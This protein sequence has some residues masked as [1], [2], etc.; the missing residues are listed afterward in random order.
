MFF[1][2]ILRG[3]RATPTI[4][5]MDLAFTKMHK[6]PKKIPSNRYAFGLCIL[7]SYAFGE[8]NLAYMSKESG[9][10]N[11]DYGILVPPRRL[12]SSLRTVSL[13]AATTS[14]D[15]RSIARPPSPA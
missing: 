10:A 9:Y 6:T 4:M 7:H 8:G 15:R 14:R 13:R 3:F 1:L 5:Q 11:R 12:F 2:E